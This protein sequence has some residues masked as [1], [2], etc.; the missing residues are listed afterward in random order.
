MDITPRMGPANIATATIGS[1]VSTGTYGSTWPSHAGEDAVA[2]P[3]DA[4]GV[5]RAKDAPACQFT[6][7]F[8]FM[9]LILPGPAGR[10]QF[11]QAAAIA[12][13]MPNQTDHA[14]LRHSERVAH[15]TMDAVSSGECRHST[16]VDATILRGVTMSDI[17][18]RGLMSAAAFTGMAG[19]GAAN[20]TD[21]AF[22]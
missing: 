8:S 1:N 22:K 16:N 14:S 19:I 21:F 13:C 10:W 18:R 12:E 20:G 4:I 15:A 3:A 9:P 7:C 17:T 5:F 2:S 11:L 6:G